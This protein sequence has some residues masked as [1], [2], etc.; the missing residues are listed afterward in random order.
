M[1]T[2]GVENVVEDI[3]KSAPPVEKPSE[4]PPTDKTPDK[5]ESTPAKEPEV[6]AD[7]KPPEPE[8][9]PDATGLT[10]FEKELV[11]QLPEDQQQAL[12]EFKPEDRAERLKWMK[13][14]YRAQ[15]RANTELGNLRK[16]I[17]AIKD[18]GI[19]GEDLVEL[20]SS[21]MIIIWPNHLRHTLQH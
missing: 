19:T 6:K 9:E 2:P 1:D 11:A 18:S 21:K 4:A 3:L 10:A 20:A 8:G 16:S 17:K 7:V 14:S 12:S 13:V 15:A 5:G